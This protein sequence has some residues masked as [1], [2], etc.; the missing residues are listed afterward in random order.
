M[1]LHPCGRH[2]I[3]V[4]GVYF[5]PVEVTPRDRLLYMIRLPGNPILGEGKPENQNHAV[6]FAHGETL[7]TLDMNQDNYMGEAFKMRNLLMLFRGGVRLVG[8]REHIFSVSGGAVA[9]HPRTGPNRR[10]A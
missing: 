9:R 8:F 3:A 7:Q 10:V 4:D 1:G 6:I 5:V 2:Y